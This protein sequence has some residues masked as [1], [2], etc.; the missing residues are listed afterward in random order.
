MQREDLWMIIDEIYKPALLFMCHI[1]C[2][3]HIQFK[4][5]A[6]NLCLEIKICGL[7]PKGGFSLEVGGVIS[8]VTDSTCP[9]LTLMELG[10]TCEKDIWMLSPCISML[11][12][13][14]IFSI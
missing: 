11:A 3:P 7:G 14:S 8:G 12:L 9:D 2:S 1:N 13:C 6:I 4:R 5:Q 10:A